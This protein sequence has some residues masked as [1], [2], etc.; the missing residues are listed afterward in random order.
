MGF[1][2]IA[3]ARALRIDGV[4]IPNRGEDERAEGYGENN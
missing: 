4:K 3:L 1:E 2:C